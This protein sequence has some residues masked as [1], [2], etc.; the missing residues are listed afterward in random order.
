VLRLN[1]TTALTYNT[2]PEWRRVMVLPLEARLAAFADASTRREL[3]AAAERQTERPLALRFGELTVESV[4]SDALRPLE[5][6]VVDD[7]AR[8]RGC[9]PLDA[10]LDISVADG[11]RTSFRTP[12]VADDEESWARR[13]AHWNDPRVLIGASDAGA[14]MDTIAKFA[15]CTDFC[16]PTVRERR[17]LSLEDAVQKVTDAPARFY[18]LHDRG[19]IA[20][21]RRADVVVLDPTTLRTGPVRLRDDLPGGEPRLF[22]DAVGIE[23]VFVNG[24]EIVRGGE[25]TGATPG[26]VLRSGRDTRTPA[27]SER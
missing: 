26:T 18:G 19:R 11:L 14:H 22:A 13:R 20:A 4:R 8:E 1:L 3:A 10:F 16:G 6:R 9:T 15:Y 21:G 23:H 27:R 5:G 2:M 24:V 12:P 17:L 25:P 7:I